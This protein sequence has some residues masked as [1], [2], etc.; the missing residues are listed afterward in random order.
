MAAPAV[1]QWDQAPHR[2]ALPSVTRE[3]GREGQYLWQVEM[4]EDALVAL[5]LVAVGRD[6]RGPATGA[7]SAC[8]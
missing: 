7:L 5:P 4:K 1:G 8:R 2:L 6:R 3:R